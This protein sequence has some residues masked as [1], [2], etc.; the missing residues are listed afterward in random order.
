MRDFFS[1]SKIPPLKEGDMVTMG[2]GLGRRLSGKTFRMEG[3]VL[4]QVRAT[5]RRKKSA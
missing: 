2:K 1:N 5:K 4:K 3:G